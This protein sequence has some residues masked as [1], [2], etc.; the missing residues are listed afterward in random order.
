MSAAA[1]ESANTTWTSDE[2]RELNATWTSNEL[3]IQG[4][5]DGAYK[6][7]HTGLKKKIASSKKDTTRTTEKDKQTKKVKDINLLATRIL[8]KPL[9]ATESHDLYTVNP[10]PAWAI[11]RR[12]GACRLKDPQS[13]STIYWC[14]EDIPI[15]QDIVAKY[16]EMHQLTKSDVF[17]WVYQ[18]RIPDVDTARQPLRLHEASKTQ[19]YPFII[20]DTEDGREMKAEASV[21]LSSNG[22]KSYNASRRSGYIV[23]RDLVLV[24]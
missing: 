2:L 10:A 23:L 18:P 16:R 20:I 14:C 21:V 8:G 9:T 12:F 19:R 17:L 13:P 5:E 7:V 3:R 4:K 1:E 6:Q 11:L 24:K 22:I 15:Q